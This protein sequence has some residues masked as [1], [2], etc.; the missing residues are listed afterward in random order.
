M[1]KKKW[2]KKKK[3]IFIISLLVA[4]LILT[5][6]LIT[7]LTT[8]D[9]TQNTL[10]PVSDTKTE[11]NRVFS[12]DDINKAT[13]LTQQYIDILSQYDGKPGYLS[14]EIDQT[15]NEINEKVKK[16]LKL[17]YDTE[18]SSAFIVTRALNSI[19]S[20]NNKLRLNKNLF[21]I[22]MAEEIYYKTIKVHE[23]IIPLTYTLE[24]GQVMKYELNFVK[25]ING[26]LKVIEGFLIQG[27]DIKKL[28][29]KATMDTLNQQRYLDEAKEMGIQ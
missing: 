8:K 7:L 26:E 6:A 2:D 11:E 10:N 16:Q 1:K 3:K 14:N 9:N 18:Y 27:E 24:N 20:D 19:T 12:K 4:L 23:L 5:G 25:T 15:C 13:L 17:F 29:D 28:N 21:V 22:G